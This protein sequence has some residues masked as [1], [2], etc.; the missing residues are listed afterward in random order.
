MGILTT[1]TI[2]AKLLICYI[3]GIVNFKG[4]KFNRYRPRNGQKANAYRIAEK[5]M[6]KQPPGKLSCK[7]KVKFTL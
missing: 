4:S 6:G 2:R 5:P 7:V 3:Y 1:H